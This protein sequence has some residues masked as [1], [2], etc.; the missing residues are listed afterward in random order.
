MNSGLPNILS[1]IRDFPLPPPP[2]WYQRPTTYVLLVVAIIIAGALVRAAW[3]LWKFL[4][5][6][7]RGFPVLP[8]D[9][10][11]PNDIA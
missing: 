4:R 5:P 8:R 2:P 6:E 9:S 10:N 11:T 7:R 1:L 3:V